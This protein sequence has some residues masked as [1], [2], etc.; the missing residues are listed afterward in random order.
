MKRSPA[1]PW[2]RRQLRDPRDQLLFLPRH[3]ARREETLRTPRGPRSRSAGRR[4]AGRGLQFLAR[5]VPPKRRRPRRATRPKA[6]RL[7]RDV[8]VGRVDARQIADSR[9]RGSDASTP[10]S[11]LS[12]HAPTFIRQI[13]FRG[14]ARSNRRFSELLPVKP[15]Y[16]GASP[17]FTGRS[18]ESVGFSGRSTKEAICRINVG[19]RCG[20]S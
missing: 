12:L 8:P 14:F 16:L 5:A 13:T 3:L 17:I 2:L 1:A 9:H 4:V 7:S 6:P 20:H 11:V 19:S 18:P 15:T 10:V